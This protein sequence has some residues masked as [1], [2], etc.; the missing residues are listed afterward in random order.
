MHKV[1]FIGA[2]PYGEALLTREG[3]RILEQA[4][5][6]LYDHL[7]D[8]S[9]LDIVQGECIYVGKQASHH[10][11]PQ[12]EIN[13][14]LIEKA[15]QYH[16]V[17]RLKGGDSFVFGRG[18]EEAQTLKQ[19]NISFS[20]IPGISSCIAAA[21]LAGIPVT[22]RGVA[23]GFQVMSA[24]LQDHEMHIDTSQVQDPSIT[25][26]FLMGLSRVHK[27]CEKLRE[28][29]RDMHT[30]IAIISQA[31][32]PHQKV[33]T[34]TLSTIEVAMKTETLVSPAIIV[35]GDVVKLR[36]DLHFYE[37]AP[38][39][40][41]RVLVRKIGK[42]RSSLSL[43]LTQAGAD[44]KEAQVGKIV[45]LEVGEEIKR[46]MQYDTLVFTSKYAIR[47]M[48]QALYKQGLDARV[49]H[50]KQIVVL[51]KSVA[52]QLLE[53]ALVADRM[54]EGTHKDMMEDCELKSMK[55]I[56]IKAS[57][58]LLDTCAMDSLS[59]YE[60]VVCPQTHME[61]TFDAIFFTSAS[62]VERYEKE[63]EEEVCVS[64]GD[65]TSKAL[66]KRNATHIIQA[67]VP[68][69]EQMVERY[70]KEVTSCIEEED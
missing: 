58:S 28:A 56:H 19:A 17:V 24:H 9:I 5:C 70:I 46:V 48:F 18:G 66:R 36:Q 49:L 14:L 35:V 51:G 23:R 50:D 4:D 11:M 41:K 29:N 38:L 65:S 30:P 26:I 33:L 59:V 67:D 43:K 15:K 13:A 16:T 3:Y 8:E 53:Y 63:F 10:H 37:K 1:Y 54:I 2:G 42:A 52:Q 61:E 39:Y 40:G 31:A 25:L 20:F 22:Y 45:F 34:A 7:L 47:G 64:I 57:Q 27:I 60:N 62:S 44:V 6:V 32:S 21:E 68:S 12:H 69:Y 55:C